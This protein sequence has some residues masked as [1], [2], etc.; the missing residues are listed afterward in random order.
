LADLNAVGV[1]I[2]KIFIIPKGDVMMDN[3]KK[4]GDFFGNTFGDNT[5]IQSEN[6]NQSKITK[7]GE[8]NKAYQGLLKDIMNIKDET[9]QEH[10]KYLAEQLKGAAEK[11][12]NTTVKKMVTFLGNILGHTASLASIASF[13]GISL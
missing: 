5:A 2:E 7:S 11:G 1:N 9:Q 6:I 10:A 4:I 13:F 3:S 8:F 12:D